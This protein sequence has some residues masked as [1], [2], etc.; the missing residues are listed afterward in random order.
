[1]SSRIELPVFH[2]IIMKIAAVGVLLGPTVFLLVA[3]SFMGQTGNEEVTD[4]DHQMVFRLT[5]FAMASMVVFNLVALYAP[6]LAVKIAR[7]KSGTDADLGQAVFTGLL[8]RY[9]SSSGASILGLASI[10][11]GAICGYMPW[12]IWVNLLPLAIV[13][14]VVITTFPTRKRVESQ[15]SQLTTQN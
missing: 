1:M 14:A 9:G 10:A 15:I 2:L 8:I 6:K 7:R 4:Q 11:M 5:S 3:L 12:Y 13:Y